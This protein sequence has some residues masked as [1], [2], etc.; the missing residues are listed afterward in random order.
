[1]THDF[2]TQ[3]VKPLRMKKTKCA[4]L[5]FMRPRIG[6]KTPGRAL[7]VA[8]DK[9][10]PIVPG[11]GARYIYWVHFFKSNDVAG[12]HF[13]HKKLELFYPV[14]GNFT[15][16]LE[17]PVTH[18]KETIRLKEKQH[19]V[20]FIPTFLAHTVVAEN[21]HALLLVVASSSDVEKDTFPY[22]IV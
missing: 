19:H 3:Y 4:R 14:R 17:H 2:K 8:F 16:H 5:F 21:A 9:T 12:N 7:H 20:L 1:M 10:L 15:V 22:T 6:E 11:F 13:H 18:K